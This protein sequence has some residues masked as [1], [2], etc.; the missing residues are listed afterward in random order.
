MKLRS[1]GQG[2]LHRGHLNRSTVFCRTV[3]KECMREIVE[4]TGPISVLT[5]L[6]NSLRFVDLLGTRTDYRKKID[7]N[8]GVSMAFGVI[9][10]EALAER[11]AAGL[12]AQLIDVREADELA[13]AA[14]GG[15]QR[16]SL[17]EFGVWGSQISAL[18]DP[19]QETI[20]LCHHGVRSAQMCSFLVSQGFTQVFNVRGGIAAFSQIDPTI[21]QY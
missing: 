8:Y 20:V 10:V 7:E 15:F 3:E 12:T 19:E 4:L 13:I 1:R 16:F 14:L 11:L 21:P 17:S 9:T 5:H 18:L 2:T 6:L